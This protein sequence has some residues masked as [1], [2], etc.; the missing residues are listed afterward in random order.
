LR[1]SAARPT[2]SGRLRLKRVLSAASLVGC[3]LAALSPTAEASAPEFGI[4]AAEVELSAVQAGRHPDLIATLDFKSQSTSPRADPESFALELPAGLIGNPQGLPSCPLVKFFEAF[5][6]PCPQDSQVGVID[7]RFAGAANFLRE[8][9]YSL[10][11]SED[12]VA[13]LGFIGFL[14]PYIL[15]VDVRS[16]GDYG[17]T[18]SASNLPTALSVESLRAKIWGVPPDPAHD[19]ERITPMEAFECAGDPTPCNV[20]GSRPSTFPPVPFVTNPAQCGPL[21]FE[22]RTTTYSLPGREFAATLQSAPI[23]DCEKVPFNPSLSVSTGN[24]AAGAATALEVDLKLAQSEGAS[25]I[26]PS[27]LRSASIA[28]PE[29]MTLNASAA[30]G[31]RGCSAEEAGYASTAPAVCRHESKTGSVELV[32]PLLPRAATG[33]IFLRTPAPGNPYRFWLSV[34]GLGMDVV[35]PVEIVA[36]A[37]SGRL[38]A[39]ISELPQLPLEEL[40]IRFNGGPRAPLTNPSSCG[41][42]A[43][44]FRLAPWSGNPSAA[45]EAQIIVD[46]SCTPPTFAPKLSAGVIEP[47]VASHSPFVFKLTSVDGES[48]LSRIAMTLPPGELAT[49]AGVPACRGPAVVTGECDP[50]SRVG[51]IRVGIGSAESP[52]WIPQENADSGAI[53]LA[54]PYES[55][56]YSLVFRLPAQAGPFE[57]G[58]L[59]VRAAV[60]L[61]PRTAQLT[62]RSDPLPQLV[63][64]LPLRYR[65][66]YL[67]LDRPGFMVNPTSCEPEKMSATVMAN[68]GEIASVSSRFQLVECGALRFRPQIA[69]S[70]SGGLARNGHPRVTT[71]LRSVP[72]ESRIAAAALTFPRGQ[73]LDL[74]HVRA[75]CARDRAAGACPPR[76]RVGYVRL[77]S[78]LV[79]PP[80]EG[81][82]YLRASRHRFPDLVADVR[83]SDLHLDLRG[84]TGAPAG[85]LRIR[86]GSIPDIPISKAV[87][88]LAGGRRGILVNSESLCR[89]RRAA[90]SFTAHSGKRFRLRPPLHLRGQC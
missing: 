4:R 25:T 84:G 12:E 89:R 79:G 59:V 17:V 22:F 42:H 77:W 61:D 54:G 30:D 35:T 67:A 21:E 51:T 73:L 69:V 11:H 45:G 33:S 90:A 24:H 55:A 56:P 70:L 16:G 6:D 81:P 7:I 2:K 58:S 48:N 86:F 9:L 29:G 46:R 27:P 53:F 13:R 64:G 18:I 5:N 88:T 49:L 14:S 28:L 20:G 34:N 44:R 83:G 31:L 26:S 65:T 76:S 87:L 47:V 60:E 78:S 36:D 57:F 71:V 66:L 62:V 41:R 8:P 3:V 72:S 32:S 50:R 75:L 19:S 40:R 82:V 38:T 43:A 63:A 39:V 15:D 74:R 52:L 85:R 80:L 23:T 1:G 37:A 68:D 10:S